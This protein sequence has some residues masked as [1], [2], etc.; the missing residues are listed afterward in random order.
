MNIRGLLGLAICLLF[1]AFSAGLAHAGF[2]PR[3]AAEIA[4]ELDAQ[5][6][7]RMGM[8]E[9][10]LRNVTM[11]I[12]TPADLGNLNATSALSRLV[13]E[14]MSTWFVS[15]GYRVQ[16]MRK[17]RMVLFAPG[18]GELLLTRKANL[19]EKKNIDGAVILAGTYTVTSKHVRF[20]MKL[21]HT[22]SSEVLAM[23][24]STLPMTPEVREMVRG[25]GGLNFTGLQPTV[26]TR[27]GS[28]TALY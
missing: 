1:L 22:A 10:P 27:L 20:N 6:A 24:S 28:P 18:K 2:I 25:S 8:A 13:A 26:S 7:A 4:D 5:L 19:L 11:L 17:G 3:M 9:R 12:T 21:I 15:V 16:E 23:A 14:E